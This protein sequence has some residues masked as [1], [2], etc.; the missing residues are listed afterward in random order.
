MI[1]VRSGTARLF[2]QIFVTVLTVPFVFP[3]VVMVFGSLSG[4]GW[5]NYAAVL[6]LPQLPAFFR[7]SLAIAALTIAIVYVATMLAAFAFAKLPIRGK[8]FLF[9]LLMAALTLPEVVLITPLFVT[10]TRTNIYNTY[11]AVV[12]PLAALQIP[13]TILISRTFVQNLPDELLEAARIDGASTFRAFIHV[14]LPITRPI[15]AVIVVLT[16]IGAWNSY[17]LPLVFLQSVDNQVVTQVPSFFQGQYNDDQP[18]VLASAVITAIPEVLAYVLLQKWF[19][20][21]IAAG[22]LK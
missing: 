18:K 2:L 12:L 5:G 3:L 9:W 15:A 11:W 4:A 7:N 19:E 13:F 20:R 22:A 16:L 17:L 21:G 1:E 6:A 10:A 8:E 14:I